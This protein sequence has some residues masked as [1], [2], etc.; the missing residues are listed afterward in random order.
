[1]K[2]LKIVIFCINWANH[3]IGHQ[4]PNWTHYAFPGITINSKSRLY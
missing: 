3:P 4:L 1:M 2:R